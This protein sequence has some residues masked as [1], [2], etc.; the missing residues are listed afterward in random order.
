MW[1]YE[2]ADLFGLAAA[3][4]DGIVN[5]HAFVDGNKRTGFIA[6]ALFLET[7]GYRFKASEVQVVTMTLGLADKSL[8]AAEY[9]QWLRDNCD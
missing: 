1:G 4:A 7:N 9:A 8:S 5:N 2:G 3:Y 6:A